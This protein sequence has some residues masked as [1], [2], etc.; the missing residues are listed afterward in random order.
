MNRQENRGA[1]GL[2][3]WVDQDDCPKL[4]PISSVLEAYRE[5][6]GSPPPSRLNYCTNLILSAGGTPQMSLQHTECAFPCLDSVMVLYRPCYQMIGPRVLAWPVSVGEIKRSFW[7]QYQD[8]VSKAAGIIFVNLAMASQN[9]LSILQTHSF[10][11]SLSLS[12]SLP[13]PLPLSLPLSLHLSVSLPC[14]CV[15]VCVCVC[16]CVCVGVY[17]LNGILKGHLP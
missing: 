5:G 12:L 15:C 8:P 16:M 17:R 4:V 10:C 13:L 11:L 2:W 7:E 14:V 3:A 6:R 9:I 1:C